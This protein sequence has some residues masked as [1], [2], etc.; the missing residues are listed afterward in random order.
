MKK[1]T[2]IYLIT[3]IFCFFELWFSLKYT[4]AYPGLTY[5][6]FAIVKEYGLNQ[7]KEGNSAYIYLVED[8]QSY[9]KKDSSS[10][11]YLSFID[12]NLVNNPVINYKLPNPWLMNMELCATINDVTYQCPGW[13]VFEKLDLPSI[14]K[15]K[16]IPM[17]N[18]YN[19]PKKK[20]LN[21]YEYNTNDI[22]ELVN[23]LK[24]SMDDHIKSKGG[25]N[26]N[27]QNLQI[28]WLYKNNG[29]KAKSYTINLK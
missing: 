8:F 24:S 11:A 16:Y 15:S 1:T 26:F 29:A 3:V 5:P 13:K 14:A 25:K 9:I 19:F 12:S 22:F 10:F 6:Q 2:Y 28:N 27:Y 7:A 4:E 17:Y 18:L 23:F 20:S 21:G